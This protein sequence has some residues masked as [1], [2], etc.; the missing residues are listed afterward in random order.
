[1]KKSF[2]S[3][4][5]LFALV[6]GLT[7]MVKGLG[8][9]PGY[10]YLFGGVIEALG[11]LSLLVLFVNV[12]AIKRMRASRVTQLALALAVWS[13]VSLIVY[14]G[15]LNFC[16]VGD[17]IRHTVY[18]PLWTTGDIAEMTSIAGSR[19]KALQEN[20]F[21]AVYSAIRAMPNYSTAIAITSA[22]LIFF[23]QSI[24]TS[25]SIAFGILG[26]KR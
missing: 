4:T 8:T 18:F 16:V 13:L 21:F 7:I 24:F 5:G 11:A 19:Y 17:A 26:L 9:P 3:A 23:Y 1:M 2:L 14:I 22:V 25:L 20:G 15:L 6:P 12:K 10:S